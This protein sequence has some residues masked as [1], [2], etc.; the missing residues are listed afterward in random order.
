MPRRLLLLPLM[1]LA[2][3]CA[4]NQPTHSGFLSAYPSEKPRT[5]WFATYTATRA[6]VGRMRQ[7]DSFYLEE[8]AWRSPVPKEVAADPKQQR[9][10]LD[11][12]RD[13]LHQK[14]SPVRG[15]VGAPGP[16]TARVR[17]AITDDDKS[18]VWLNVL[19]T[20]LAIPIS[21]GGATIEAE[22]LAPD[23]TQIA[24]VDWG[25]VGGPLDFL[26]YYFSQDH[27]KVAIHHAAEQLARQLSPPAVVKTE[28]HHGDHGEHGEEF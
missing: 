18:V 3:G 16:R 11:T 23:G 10:L 7:I 12:L 17:A 14:L 5:E 28:V 1:L 25:E 22:V 2:G 26:G 27:A 15:F 21:N 24:A 9:V 13:Q 8:V 20:V 19:T 6:T 4:S